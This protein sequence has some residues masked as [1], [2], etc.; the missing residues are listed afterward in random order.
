[1]HTRSYRA[2]SL[3]YTAQQTAII[4]LHLIFSLHHSCTLRL[5][6]KTL[7]NTQFFRDPIDQ[8]QLETEEVPDVGLWDEEKPP[9]AETD[10]VELNYVR[11]VHMLKWIDKRARCL[12]VK[13]S[14]NPPYYFGRR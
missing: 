12:Q 13:F 3:R 2:I 11:G 5:E 6:S 10:F 9:P 7:L 14:V 1:M 8:I 4:T